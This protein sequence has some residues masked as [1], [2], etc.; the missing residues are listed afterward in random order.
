VNQADVILLADEVDRLRAEV[1]TQRDITMRLVDVNCE[2]IDRIKRLENK[3]S[4]YA[5]QETM[6]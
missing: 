2:L 6:Q 5:T 1:D 4:H 3:Q